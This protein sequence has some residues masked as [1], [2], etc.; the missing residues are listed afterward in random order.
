MDFKHQLLL[1]RI[2][3]LIIQK[4]EKDS[5]TNTNGKPQTRNS[6]LLSPFSFFL[7]H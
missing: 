6:T 4:C 3:I 7:S 5:N 1:M 2:F